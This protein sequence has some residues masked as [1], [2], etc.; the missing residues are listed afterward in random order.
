V[1]TLFPGIALRFIAFCSLGFAALGAFDMSGTFSAFAVAQKSAMAARAQNSSLSILFPH[2]ETVFHSI[3][4]INAMFIVFLVPTSIFLWRLAPRGRILL[5][6]VFG[7][8]VIYW[9]GFPL[10]KM[11]LL[12]DWAGGG[13]PSLWGTLGYIGPLAN[14]GISSQLNIA[15]PAIAL[16][17]G[18]FAYNVLD[19]RQ[20][21]A[22]LPASVP[23]SS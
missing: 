6:L 1:K 4:A 14:S 16:V 19:R 8:E 5:N 15:F 21:M 18:N 20:G 23:H 9:L 17:V 22:P 2:L 11:F 3:T 7:G 13:G 12:S 10:F